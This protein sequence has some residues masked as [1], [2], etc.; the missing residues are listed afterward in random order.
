M[1]TTVDLVDLLEGIAAA[2]K[3]EQRMYAVPIAE[4]RAIAELA[5]GGPLSAKD[6][7]RV[8]MTVDMFSRVVDR[9]AERIA[10]PL[11]QKIGELNRERDELRAIVVRIDGQIRAAL[12]AMGGGT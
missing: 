4:M 2:E 1:T 3:A 5:A 9:E 7:T 12:G 10:A 11:R 6:T 8:S